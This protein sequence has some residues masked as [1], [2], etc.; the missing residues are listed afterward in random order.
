[1]ENTNCLKEF[2][3]YV[4][5]NILGML[6]LSFYILADTFFISKGLG[7]EGL[8]AL[9]LAIPVYSLIHGSGLMLGMGGATKF[10]IYKSLGEK[11]KP[12]EAFT[13]SAA[14]AGMFA[15][16]FIASGVFLS[17]PLTAV[18]GADEA[19]FSMTYS[20]L[21]TLLL[22]S[23]AF[24]MNNIL[25]CFVRNDGNPRLS[26]LAML[27]GSFSNVILDYI[28]IFPFGMGMFGAV[29]ATAMAP[30]IS[31]TILSRHWLKPDKGFGLRKIRLEKNMAFGI[32][33]LGF[34]S[35]ITELSSGIVII[36]FN[37][38][39]L[40]LSGNVGIAAYGVVANLSLV[41]VS[42]YNGIAQGIQPLLSSAYGVRNRDAIRRIEGYAIRTM[43]VLSASIY[44]AVYFFADPITAVFNSEGNASLQLIAS[45]GL[46][47]YFTAA[48]FAGCNIILSVYFT[49]TEEALPAHIISLLRGLFLIVPMAFFLSSLWGITGVWLAFPVT[50]GLVAVLGIGIKRLG[51]MAG[52]K[53]DIS[54]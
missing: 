43:L 6:G 13:H 41:M 3:R 23:P 14:M 34:P 33:S 8:A 20:Y 45:G 12:G 10:S 40:S 4:S 39:I 51:P 21:K 16:F 24:L 31:M 9:N 36:V 26:M 44:A 15:A 30:V 54:L 22:F 2:T 46:K 17:K 32:L 50:E 49:S 29:L 37:L 53:R 11:E 1:M 25:L 42:V 28:F 47:L 27:G 48:A 7:A 5:A 52:Q 38:I 19:V 35:L 18:L